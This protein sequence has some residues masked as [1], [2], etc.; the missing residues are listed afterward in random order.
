MIAIGKVCIGLP[1][2][3]LLLR[4]TVLQTYNV[5]LPT[6]KKVQN[7]NGQDTHGLELLLTSITIVTEDASAPLERT[8]KFFRDLEVRQGHLLSILF[9]EHL[10]E[11]RGNCCYSSLCRQHS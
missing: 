5:K 11:L 4:L 1:F 2:D 6:I 10:L 9:S 8:L 7:K 3:L